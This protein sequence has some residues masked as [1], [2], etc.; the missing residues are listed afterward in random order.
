[1][2]NEHGQI[3]VRVGGT[4]SD[5]ENEYRAIRPKDCSLCCFSKT[6]MCTVVACLR[7]ERKDSM[8]VHFIKERR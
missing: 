3:E 6:D 8:G 1:M 5:G 4:F 2:I 7:T